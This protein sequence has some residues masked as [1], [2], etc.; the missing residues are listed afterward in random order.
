MNVLSSRV[1]K[2]HEFISE[3]LSNVVYGWSGS[4]AHQTG[5][6]YDESSLVSI[7]LLSLVSYSLAEN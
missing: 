4:Y 6:V 3:L 5:T 7:G 2:Q 1:G